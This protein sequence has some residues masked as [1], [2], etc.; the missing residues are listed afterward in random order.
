MGGRLWSKA[1]DAAVDEVARRG[2]QLALR[3]RGESAVAE[4][5]ADPENPDTHAALRVKVGKALNG[6]PELL[7]EIVDL[8]GQA[9]Q[10]T[11]SGDRSVAGTITGSNV[12]TR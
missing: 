12:V 4:A 5:V 11:A 3:L 8:L 2:S 10:A 9:G 7:T 1:E 6:S